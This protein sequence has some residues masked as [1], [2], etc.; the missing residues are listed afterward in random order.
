WIAF[1]ADSDGQIEVDAGAAQALL[2]EGKSLLPSGI[3]AVRGTFI[4]G[5]VVEVIDAQ[6]RLLGKGEVNYSA[7]QLDLVKGESTTF[8]REKL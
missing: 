6:G 7:G 2:Y 4:P 1:H 8:C 3:T 5:Q